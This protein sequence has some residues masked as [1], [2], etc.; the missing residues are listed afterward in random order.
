MVRDF[1]KKLVLILAILIIATGM[2]GTAYGQ[3]MEGRT[4]TSDPFEMMV[5]TTPELMSVE[6]I[7]K[8][9][10]PDVSQ[11][12]NDIMDTDIQ[13][14]DYDSV[15]AVRHLIEDA[16][17]DI[18]NEGTNISVDHLLLDAVL[19]QQQDLVERSKTDRFI[20]KY[21]DEGEDSFKEKVGDKIDESIK[22]ENLIPKEFEPV[23]ENKTE[24]TILDSVRGLFKESIDGID[25]LNR[26]EDKT[27]LIILE[28][29]VN[30][31]EFA[32]VLKDSNIEDDIEYIQPDYKM[33]LNGLDDNS[34]DA[35]NGKTIFNLEKIDDQGT[36][37]GISTDNAISTEPIEE[38]VIDE[39][40]TVEAITT[41]EAIIEELL[42]EESQNKVIVAIIDTGVDIT[43]PDLEDYIYLNP[44][45]IP[46]N[47]IDDD[48][49]GYIDDVHGWSF[50][51]NSGVVYNETLGLE[52]AHATHI[53]GIIAG[54]S[55]ADDSLLPNENIEIL[56]LKVFHNGTAYTSD[57][58]A[59]IEYAEKMGAKVVNCSFGSKNENQALKEVMENSSALFIS[60]AGNARMDLDETPVYP[61]AFNLPNNLSVTSVNHDG[62]LS[63]F[64]D[65]GENSVG[66]AALGRDIE[67]TIPFG[68]KGRYTGTSMSAGIVSATAGRIF[69]EDT[70]INASKVKVRLI[71]GADKISSLQ[72]KVNGDSRLNIEESI[73]GNIQTAIQ[74]I[75]FEEDF[76]VIGFEDVNKTMSLF[77]SSDTVK[78]SAG[79]CH[80]LILKSDGTVW[81]WGNN[82]FGQCGNV[83]RSVSSHISQ[84]IGLTDI[85]DISAGHTYSLAL[86]SD[87]T[88]WAWGD[89][90]SGQLGD[91][92]TTSRWMPIQVSGLDGVEKISAGASHSLALNNNG[93]IWS[94]GNN[95]DGQLGDGTTIDKTTPTQVSGLTNISEISAG[96]NHSLALMS[97]NSVWSWGNN[98]YGQLGDG[99]IV[100]KSVPIQLSSLTGIKK[101]ISR[102]VS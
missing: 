18:K 1:R 13:P 85:I 26:N 101:Y 78:I 100:N 40:V 83:N 27:E 90:S 60:A 24:E 8:A 94:W 58:I 7:I 89:N 50:T 95:R 32:E 80:N 44:N 33:E 65:Y 53:A 34:T 86:K 69:A 55:N 87:G 23:D 96:G 35:D 12:A 22:I 82:D 15:E 71:N 38:S 57:I 77:N 2:P 76:E 84:V 91:G 79:G 6:E 16:V 43:H 68:K 93:T 74:N 67:S 37:E 88:V 70:N 99:T 54:K 72:G 41:E 64:S 56:P 20:V 73:E 48:G 4:D 19:K 21:K 31:S 46:D 51:D 3:A 14:S 42:P 61:A 66:I 25:L 92:T 62:G 47:G 97:D 30:P 59:A 98:T 10:A 81:A 45:E 36:G 63:Y 28:D 52:Q 17:E 75:E 9:A 49:N 5:D 39:T 29:S 11:A 102:N